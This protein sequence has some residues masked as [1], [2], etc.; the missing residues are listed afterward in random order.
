VVTK[1]ALRPTIGPY[2]RVTNAYQ[3]RLLS[4]YDRWAK[5]MARQLAAQVIRGES[6]QALRQAVHL[7]MAALRAEMLEAGRRG[8][9]AAA[10]VAVGRERARTPVVQ[11]AVARQVALNA[12]L[13]TTSLLLDIEDGTTEALTITQQPLTQQAIVGHLAPFRGR[14]A[15]YGGGAWVAI[16]EVQREVALE[17]RDDRRVRWVLHPDADHCTGDDLTFGCVDLEGIY[18][19][20]AMLPTVPA[21][22]TQCRGNCRC[23]LE[24]EA[25]PGEWQ[26]GLE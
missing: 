23:S 5:G 10:S 12:N 14:V 21:G 3:K 4:I 2:E 1:P 22:R 17:D 6:R 26:R 11:S 18:D 16:F 8:I 13:I 7:E 19:N 20:W 9:T 24:V 15:G 25:S